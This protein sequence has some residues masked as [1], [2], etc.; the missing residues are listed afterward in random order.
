MQ[1]A[2]LSSAKPMCSPTWLLAVS[3]MMS[4]AL[5]TSTALHVRWT[6]GGWPIN[7]VDHPPTF[8]LGLHEFISIVGYGLCPLVG[9]S[10]LSVA[11]I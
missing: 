2:N 4:I 8:L 10:L 3:P 9:S 6:F 7:A 5:L 11:G 1:T